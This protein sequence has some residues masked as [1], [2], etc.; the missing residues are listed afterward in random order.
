ME[1]KRSPNQV[2]QDRQVLVDRWPI[3][4][5]HYWQLS[6]LVA[7]EGWALLEEQLQR[8]REGRLQG[9]SQQD[10]PEREADFERGA[11]YVLNL[12]LHLG[13]DVKDFPK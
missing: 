4:A 8:H 13:E 6:E 9:L 12:L 2:L 11:I 3:L 5:R 10:L 7:Q 1:D